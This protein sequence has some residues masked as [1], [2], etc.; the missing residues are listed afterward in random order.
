MA[1]EMYSGGSSSSESDIS[2]SSGCV[3]LEAEASFRRYRRRI[4]RRESITS[5]STNPEEEA[6]VMVLQNR[7]GLYDDFR[8]ITS[9]RDGD[10]T[11][12]VGKERKEMKGVRA[13]ISS[14]SSLLGDLISSFE[15]NKMTAKKRKQS[16]I[17][18]ALDKINKLRCATASRRQCDKG[19]GVRR[20][21]VIPMETFDPESF[22][23][24]LNYI[25]CGTL[26]V[27]A[28]TVI[29]LLNAAYMFHLPEVQQACWNFALGCVVRTDN[30]NDLFISARRY[31]E[32][33]MTNELLKTI[34]DTVCERQRDSTATRPASD[35][36]CQGS[37]RR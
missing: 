26:T 35:K 8:S 3:C 34:D 21:L 4:S 19:N 25:H 6:Y 10:V 11:F 16:Q 15:M 32:H 36:T 12:L 20:N 13:I 5:V 23:R 37:V 29:G 1:D 28:S 33:R 24:F 7:Q 2:A 14:R 30:L 17:R 27:D 22:Q 9:L 31:A 18:K